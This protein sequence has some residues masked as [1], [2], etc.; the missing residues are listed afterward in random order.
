LRALRLHLFLP[1]AA[2]V[3]AACASGGAP[4]PRSTPGAPAPS[5][6]V[7]RFLQLSASQD[8]VEMGYLFGTVQGPILRRDPA[9]EVEKRMY[10]IASVLK[11]DGYTL[12]GEEPVP[13]RT[14]SAVRVTAQLR[15]GS[16]TPNVPFVVVRGPDAR[17]FV[18]QVG[19]EAVTS[20]APAPRQ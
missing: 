16:R 12:R 8:Y 19:V 6:A 7:E 17:W 20:A 15:Q 5:A 1:L 18:E 13:G 10:A 2:L 4:A 3:L 9:T 11:N 14:G